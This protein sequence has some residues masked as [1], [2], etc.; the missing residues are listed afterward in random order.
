MKKVININFQGRVIPIEESAF[1]LLKQYTDSLKFYFA[2]EAGRDEIINDIENRI[3]EL[4]SEELKKGSLCITDMH[5]EIIMKSIG[6]P[7][8]FDQEGGNTSNQNTS[9]SS[10]FSNVKLPHASVCRNENDKVLGGVCSGLAH[11]FKLDPTVIRIFFALL[12][13]GAFGTGVLIYIVLWL[14]LP[15]A[16][17]QPNTRKRLY[18]NPDN[19]VL[20]GV[21]SGLAAYFNVSVTIPRL[22]FVIPLIIAAFTSITDDFYYG[23]IVFSGFGGTFFLAY[24]I[25][26]VVI[27]QARTASEKLEMRGEKVDL[28]SIRKGVKNELNELTIRAKD[29]S[30]EFSAKVKTWGNEVK[31]MSKDVSEASSS[32]M[33]T[34][35]PVSKSLF[36]RIFEVIGSLFKIFF[37][38]IA[39]LLFIVLFSSLIAIIFTGGG[40]LYE[41]KP[42]IIN[43]VRANLL[44]YAS[45]FLLIV[46]PTIGLMIWI[47][48]RISNRRSGS[49]YLGWTFGGL[50]AIGF[51]CAIFF[52]A[53]I[54][55]N[56]RKI[57]SVN[58]EIAIVNPTN[59]RLFVDIVPTPGKFYNLSVFDDADEMEF[60]K[61]TANQDSLLLNTIRVVLLKSPDSMYHVSISKQ[62]RSSTVKQAESTAS[63]INFPIQQQ[64]SVLSLHTGFIIDTAVQFR[65]QR[66]VVYIEVP[67]GK[68]IKISK[69]AEEYDW[70]SVRA[71]NHR[72]SRSIIIDG[73]DE[74]ID[75]YDV[76]T[77][78]WYIMTA[79]GPVVKSGGIESSKEIYPN[80]FKDTTERKKPT[81][82][83]KESEGSRKNSPMAPMI[84]VMDLM[85]KNW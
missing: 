55:K 84:S 80:D 72:R 37:L 61:I 20:G 59:D 47:I 9:S 54:S 53:D 34:I 24:L 65:N 6:R 70:F 22:I 41:L 36:I 38:L 10:T 7:E 52:G 64:D 27:P 75:G 79:H 63:K 4:F 15:A 73:D 68:Q 39:G 49:R 2:N 85:I 71:S 82:Q 28:E 30:D 33:N 46:V 11:Y 3:A 50:W 35:N 8:D 42:Y 81:T 62:A 19:K 78:I 69:L 74:N 18:R 43:G 83:H 14:V 5:V 57:S 77:G 29:M 67:V 12:A 56:F 26:W 44:L 58:Q 40:P 1:E 66:V 17:L 16:Y 48:R 23:S 25:L 32:V 13:I 31:S 21:A 51:V 60:P 45:L 76:E